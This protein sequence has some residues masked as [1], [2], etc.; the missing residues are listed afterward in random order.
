MS[1]DE[2]TGKLTYD[3]YKLSS[4]VDWLTATTSDEQTAQ[5]WYRVFQEWKETLAGE[6]NGNSGQ[7]RWS[8][9]GYIGWSIS[10][11][12]IG[13][14]KNDGFIVVLSG[15]DT[16]KLWRH[17]AQHRQRITRMDL[18]V[19]ITAGFELPGVA[20]KYYSTLSGEDKSKRSYSVIRNTKGGQTLYVGARSSDQFGR[21]YDKGAQSGTYPSGFK[22]RYE[23]EYKKPRANIAAKAL[24]AFEAQEAKRVV[25]TVYHWFEERGVRPL[26]SS[27]GDG[28]RLETEAKVDSDKKKLNWLRAQVSPSVEYLLSRGR[29][30]EA[31]VALGLLDFDIGAYERSLEETMKG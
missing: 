1:F 20:E 28:I 15:P 14:N 2:I 24:M 22:W 21:V 29:G 19:T 31:L 11:M 25:S 3:D 16:S 10:G 5:G 13:G 7:K 17:F 9:L 18:A 27:S 12:R 4:G 26:F 30:R 23:V 8:A 6:H